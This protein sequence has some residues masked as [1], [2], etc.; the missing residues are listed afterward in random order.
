MRKSKWLVLEDR[1]K[2]EEMYNSGAAVQE[3]ADQMHRN[4][5]TIYNE[6]R[7]GET[8]AM[9]ANGRPGYSAELAQKRTYEIKQE[10]RGLAAVAE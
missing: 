3:I 6:L 1:K 2:I 5:A 10:W 8:G 7:R 9:D 4:R